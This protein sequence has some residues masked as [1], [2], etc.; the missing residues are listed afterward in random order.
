MKSE[1]AYLHGAIH[2]GYIYTGKSKGKVA[3][4]T[5]KNKEWL[6]NIKTIIEESDGK[7][8]IFPQRN[9]H[10]LETKFSNLF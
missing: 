1:I 8:C 3:V 10:V 6:E 7:A 9:I 4:I 5:Q 2:D